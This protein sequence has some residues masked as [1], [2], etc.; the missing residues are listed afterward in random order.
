MLDE[1]GLHQ[2]VED[3]VLTNPLHRAAAGG[4]Q[5]G[6]LHPAWVAGGTEDM[7][8]GLQAKAEQEA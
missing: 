3:V 2:V 1:V 8:A 7:H 4:A 6:P 5:G